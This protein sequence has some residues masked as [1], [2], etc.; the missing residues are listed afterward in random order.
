MRAEQN[1]DMSASGYDVD[2][3]YMYFKAGVYNQ[4]DTGEA[5]DFVQ[6][7]FYELE[8]RHNEYEH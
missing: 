5:D 4:N 1:I 2:K 6:A 3:D 7:T 8:T